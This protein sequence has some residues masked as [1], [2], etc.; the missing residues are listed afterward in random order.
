[1]SSECHVQSPP[2]TVGGKRR[3]SADRGRARGLRRPRWLVPVLA[4]ASL[5]A[6]CSAGPGTQEELTQIL[7]DTGMTEDQATC[8]SDAVFEEYGA[9]ED[10]LSAISAAPDL[11]FLDGEDGVPGF[12]EFFDRAVADCAGSGPTVS[13]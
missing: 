13:N 2:T 7:A 11:D 1:M 8:V 10:A 3:S 4:V 12:T 9:D 5:G 6:A